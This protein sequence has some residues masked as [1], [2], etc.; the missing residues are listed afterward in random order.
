[1]LRLGFA[2]A[3]LGFTDIA[4]AAQHLAQVLASGEWQSDAF[5]VRAAVT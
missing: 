4:H 1:V 2:P 3:Y 5:R